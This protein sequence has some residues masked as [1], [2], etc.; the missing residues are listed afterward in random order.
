MLRAA[1]SPQTAALVSATLDRDLGGIA[2]RDLPSHL[3][4][5]VR[6]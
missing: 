2:D 3:S 1:L 5:V 4:T 6:L